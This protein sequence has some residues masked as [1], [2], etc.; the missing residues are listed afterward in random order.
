MKK[1]KSDII[2]ELAFKGRIPNNKAEVIVNTTFEAISKA[3]QKRQRVEIRGF[4]SFISR[5]YRSYKGRN[6]RT[7]EVIRV[8]A[9]HMP[10]FKAGKELRDY[11]KDN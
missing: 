1:T 4:G 9:K 7:S 3:L 10:F 8:K 11:L 6:P 2:S 5:S